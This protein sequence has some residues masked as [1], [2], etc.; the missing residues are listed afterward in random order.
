MEYASYWVYFRG[1]RHNPHV[2]GG[3]AAMPF[4]DIYAA[5]RA[6]D[7]LRDKHP[8]ERQI[9]V[10]EITD[11]GLIDVGLC[12]WNRKPFASEVAA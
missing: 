8:K 2:K 7:L 10:V 4:N 5:R 11:G 1:Q 6:A 9:H 3:E 12:G